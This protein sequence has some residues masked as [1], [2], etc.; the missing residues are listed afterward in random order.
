MHIAVELSQPLADLSA[1]FV[2][3]RNRELMDI[4]Q[5]F[6]TWRDRPRIAPAAKYRRASPTASIAPR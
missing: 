5:A 3:E 4:F 2:V 1:S 6:V